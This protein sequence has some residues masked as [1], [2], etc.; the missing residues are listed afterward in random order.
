MTA[1]LSRFRVIEHRASGDR[2]LY[3]PTVGDFAFQ[4]FR[5]ACQQVLD[6]AAP[7]PNSIG[8]VSL[9]LEYFEVEGVLEVSNWHLV[10]D[11][12]SARANAIREKFV[13]SGHAFGPNGRPL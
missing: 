2:I 10:D 5:Y 1:E 6:D 3:F 13:G 9:W 11:L 7:G 12:K 4:H 8:D